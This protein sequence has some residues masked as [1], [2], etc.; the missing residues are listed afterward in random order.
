ML[1]GDESVSTLLRLWVA[2]ELYFNSLFYAAHEAFTETSTSNPELYPDILFNV[3]LTK[4]GDRKVTETGNRDEA[5]KEEALLACE[6]VKW[7]SLVHIMGMASVLS[8]PIISVYPSV[9][10]QYRCLVNRVINPRPSAISMPPK[11]EAIH[12]LWT[13]DGNLD[14][15]PKSWYT[16]N[17]F[18]PLCVVTAGEKQDF[19]STSTSSTQ[20]PKQGTLS[21]FF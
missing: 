14:N 9:E 20:K 15:R 13:R 3:A 11:E 21:L 8:R 16:P 2:G 17:H 5:V 19:P 18:V 10:F 6:V 7:S 1:F 12:I 4:R